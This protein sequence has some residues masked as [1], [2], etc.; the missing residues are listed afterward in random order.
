MYNLIQFSDLRLALDL[1]GNAG[2]VAKVIGAV[3]GS[4]AVA[5]RDY[6]RIG[7]DLVDEGMDYETLMEYALSAAG[8]TTNESVVETLYSNVVGTPPS[9]QEIN[10]FTGLLDSGAHTFGSLGVFAADLDLNLSNIDFV[11]L[12]YS[13]LE[14]I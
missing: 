5:N 13:G 1:D 7:L 4:D 3:F 11:G 12:S 9:Q 6:V 14:Y 8:A 2:T 10:E